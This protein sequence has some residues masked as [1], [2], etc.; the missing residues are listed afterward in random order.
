ML[1][2][3]CGKDGTEGVAVTGEKT[4]THGAWRA[5]LLRLGHARLQLDHLSRVPPLARGDGGSYA[6]L[7]DKGGQHRQAS[8]KKSGKDDDPRELC[9]ARLV[10]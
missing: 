4:E 10:E 5:V 2:A 6:Q 3:T 8:Y 9:R 1:L 7:S